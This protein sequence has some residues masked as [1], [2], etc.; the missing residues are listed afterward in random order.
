[1]NVPFYIAKRYF[2]SKKSKNAINIITFISMTGIAVGTAA[3][4]VVLSVFNGFDEVIKSLMNSFDPDLKIT[5]VEGKT[6]EPLDAGKNKI[7]EIKGIEEV[8]EVLEENALIK[9]DER[10][11]IATLKGVDD[12]YVSVSGIDSMMSDGA[13]NLYEKG[14]PMAIVG[15]GI[16][17]SLHIGLNFIQPLIFYIPDRTKQVNMANPSAAINKTAVFPSGVFS[18][19]Q[20]YDSKFVI[21]P[22][23]VV[24]DLLDHQTAVT[25]L[26]IKLTKKANL[27]AI[28]HEVEKIAGDL[29][30]VQNRAQQNEIFY[31]VM[32]SEKW[33][34]FLILTLILLIAS[35][36]VIGSLGMVIIDKK[37]DIS[38][39]SDLGAGKV[40]IRKIFLTEGWLISIVG[41][42]IG[43]IIGTVISLAQQ[44][45]ELIKIGG[46]GTFVIDAYPVS[47]HPGD[48][49]LVW[50]T[51]LLIGFFAAYIPSRKIA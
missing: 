24:R 29:F 41:S 49:L 25:A 36:N 3:L 48:I 42:I 38:I 44:N 37:D 23:E 43:V 20:E 46:S 17:Y 50:M 13:F 4:I 10:Q 6:F 27:K 18:I 1:L 34:T 47:Y 32:K 7:L 45:F 30:K 19:E 51:V 15:R 11:F 5:A 9:Y 2:V 12:A 21:V 31:R 14:K 22:I 28:Q 33:V 8:S 40:L 39:L 16:A 26:E 35:F